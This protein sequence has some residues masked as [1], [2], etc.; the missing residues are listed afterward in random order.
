MARSARVL[1]STNNFPEFTGRVCPAPCENACV[2]GINEDPVAIKEIEM[3]IADR[4]FREGWIVPEPPA[5]AHRQE[6]R[7]RRQRTRRPGRRATTESRRPPV[8]VFEKPTGRADLLMYGIPDFKL[9][10]PRSGAASQQMEAEGVKFRATPTSAPTFRR[11]SCATTSTPSCSAAAHRAARSADPRPRTSRA[12]TSPW[13]S[14]AAEQAQP[15]RQDADPGHPRRRSSVA[16]PASTSH[17]HRRRRHRSPLSDLAAV[18]PDASPGKLARRR[19]PPG[20]CG[21]DGALHRR[22]RA[23]DRTGNWRWASPGRS[24][25][26]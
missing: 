18:A 12:S 20:V 9:E 5:E 13:S 21:V 15:G 10:K 17:H 1:H 25:A 22:K 26:A 23:C 14:A 16:P 24:R 19:R 6:G 2:L 4:G 11:R 7:R 3:T 8:T